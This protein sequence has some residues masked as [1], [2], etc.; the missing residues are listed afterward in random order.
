MTGMEHAIEQVAAAVRPVLDAHA[1]VL[2]SVCACGLD[3][4][5]EHGKYQQARRAH[6]A[7]VVARALAEAGWLAPAPLGR[8]WAVEVTDPWGEL[9]YDR[10]PTREAAED[11]RW[12]DGND[13][14]V[15]R[16]V[17]AWE[18]A[19]GIDRSEGGKAATS[20]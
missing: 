13:R 4:G 19:D 14:L 6:T 17:T 11:A 5:A 8:E 10:H 16:Y 7:E 12:S 3:L 15:H 1:W 18:P 9:R 2:D 20:G